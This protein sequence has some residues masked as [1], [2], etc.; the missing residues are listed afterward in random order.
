MS[1]RT[2]L[3]EPLDVTAACLRGGVGGGAE[4]GGHTQASG[5]AGI[6]AGCVS[7]LKIGMQQ[8]SR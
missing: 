7:W 4:G 1:Q 5:E 2:F 8:M 3:T 6:H